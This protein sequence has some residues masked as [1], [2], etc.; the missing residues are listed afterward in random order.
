MDNAEFTTEIGIILDDIRAHSAKDAV[1]AVIALVI[2]LFQAE[3]KSAYKMHDQYITDDFDATVDNPLAVMNTVPTGMYSS[4]IT[5]LNGAG[6]RTVRLYAEKLHDRPD[7]DIWSTLNALNISA[8]DALKKEKALVVL[9]LLSKSLL[10]R[11]LIAI[12]RKMRT[13]WETQNAVLIRRHEIAA[14]ILRQNCRGD[15]TAFI[16]DVEAIMGELPA[17][18]PVAKPDG[19]I[20]KWV[21]ALYQ[22]VLKD[23]ENICE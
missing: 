9:L 3:K 6:C 14:G 18:I 23:L 13:D 22:Q 15:A 19:A 17:F 11:R 5:C 7:A 4:P 12:N 16:K 2:R 21:L 8:D 10:R 1:A 20:R